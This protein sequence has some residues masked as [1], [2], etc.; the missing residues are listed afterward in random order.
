MKPEPKYH[1]P[2]TGKSQ[3]LFDKLIPVY[4]VKYTSPDHEWKGETVNIVLEADNEQDAIDKAMKN[5][6]FINYIDMNHF[7]KKYFSAHK[8]VGNYVIGKVNH[9][10]GNLAL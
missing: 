3:K 1:N 7:D 10:K 8:P 2:K 5:Q 9:F 6:E 4:N